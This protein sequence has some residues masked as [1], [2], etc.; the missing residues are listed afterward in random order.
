MDGVGEVDSMGRQMKGVGHGE[1]ILD[2]YVF[3]SQQLSEGHRDGGLLKA[4]ECTEDPGGFEQDCLG[5][6]DRASGEEGFGGC[7]L[8][9]VICR[10]QANQDVSIDRCHDAE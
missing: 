3:E 8:P 7:G 4:V 1:R 6:P 10:E 2:A 9:G 5:D